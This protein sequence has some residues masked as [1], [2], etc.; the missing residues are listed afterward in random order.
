MMSHDPAV[1]EEEEGHMGGVV[2]ALPF[3][4]LV[5]N[6][7]EELQTSL[8]K[9]RMKNLK[10]RTKPRD[11]AR[12]LLRNP[13]EEN[14]EPTDEEGGLVIDETSR[15]V[16][17][18]SVPEHKIRSAVIMP[19]GDNP[20]ASPSN[21]S[22]PD[23][24]MS[25]AVPEA[26]PS[27]DKHITTT[28]LEEESTLD[29]GMGATLR[30][31]KERGL[32]ASTSTNSDLNALDRKRNIF[33]T[34]K[35]KLIAQ[36]EVQ[37]KTQ[38]EKDRA[39][40]KLARMSAAEKSRYEEEMNRTRDFFVS[41]KLNALYQQN[42]TPNVTIEYHDE[43]GRLLDQKE[44]FKNLSHSFHGKGSGSAKTEKHLQKIRDEQRREAGSVLD[45]SAGATGG[46]RGAAESTSRRNKQAGVRLA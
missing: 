23:I 27:E 4:N 40:G 8:M 32:V 16:A 19:S 20:A 2:S 29:Q 22:A 38:R 6:D 24:D 41:S 14:D 5:A 25:D 39:S 42:Y 45:A 11:I 10:Q 26:V 21:H 34:E 43:H 7:D 36:A 37:A 33:L 9:Q 12:E 44:A 31:M 3:D 15:F 17:G 1:E 30:L 18:L 13:V 28:G 46:Y 35:K